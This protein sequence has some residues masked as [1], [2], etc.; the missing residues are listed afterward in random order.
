MESKNNKSIKLVLFLSI[1]ILIGMPEGFEAVNDNV[2]I[3]EDESKKIS[4]LRN[5]VINNKENL[6]LKIISAPTLGNA[7]VDGWKIEYIP[8][9]NVNGN[10]KFNYQIDNGFSTD[11]ATVN[12]SISPVNDAPTKVEL[13]SGA[14]NE[15]QPSGTEVG[16][17]KTVDPDFEDSFIYE[18]SDDGQSDNE[19]FTIKGNTIFT[20]IALDFEAKSTF[21]LQVMSKDRKNAS[22]ISSVDV[23][24]ADVNE[25]PV[26]DGQAQL[27]VTHPE[28]GGRIVSKISVVDPDVT[29]SSVKYKVTGGEDKNRFKITR[30]GD[31]TFLR[32]PDFENP[33]DSNRDNI[34]NVEFKAMDSKDNNLFTSGSATITISDSQEKT[35]KSI[36]SR[37]FVAWTVDHLPYHIL[38]E[39]AVKDYIN[40]RFS[41]DG[42]SY[43]RI[44]DVN[45]ESISHLDP[46]DQIIIVQQK[47]NAKEI[48]E[49]WY[50]N[51]LE[52]TVINRERVDWVFSQDIQEVLIAKDQYLN[53]DSET[54]FHKTEADRLMASFGSKFAVWHPNNFVMSLTS[55]SMR[56]NLLQY[57]TNISVGNEL[58]GLPG[59]L[60]GSSELGIATRNSEFGVRLPFTFDFNVDQKPEYISPDYLG[61]YSKVNINNLFSTKSDFHGLMGFSFYPRSTGSL[62]T[63]TGF[64]STDSIDDKSRYVNIL[65]SYAM[66][67]STVD[68]PLRLGLVGRITASPGIHYMK[69]AHR[70]KKEDLLYERNFYSTADSIKTFTDDKSYSTQNSFYIRF[71]VLGK[72]GHKPELLEK[73]SYFNFIQIYRVP[74]YEFS[75]QFISSLSTIMTLNINIIDDFSV[76]MSRFTRSSSLEGNWVPESNTWFGIRYRANF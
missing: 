25:G 41:N 64:F 42:E 57:A 44:D 51:G 28:D 22:V 56:S 49:I 58:I 16:K 47:G 5:D 15:N 11:T 20:S 65:D 4:I 13:M 39:D 34:Y 36:D 12:I 37:K 2:P 30:S 43:S 32:E 14:V 21:K 45:G 62:K 60:S 63:D 75:L 52:Y 48:Y 3:L 38:M 66:A 46:N 19:F 72:V 10:D 6:D 40:M 35:I 69:I 9:K 23:L 74:F 27:I 29:Q 50:G 59:A 24:V 67:S 17:L 73:L 53:S 54:V 70:S 8:N 76:S 7:S 68:V 31:L 61:L 26:F 33:T 55:L 18:F 1:S 71:D